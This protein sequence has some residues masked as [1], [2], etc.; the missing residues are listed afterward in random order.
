MQFSNSNLEQRLLETSAGQ[1][2]YDSLIQ[3]NVDIRTVPLE[4]VK[5]M[6]VAECRYRRMCGF[7]DYNSATLVAG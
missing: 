7:A 4:V 3:A 5:R 6:L 1:A 2:V